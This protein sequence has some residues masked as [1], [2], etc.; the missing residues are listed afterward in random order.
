MTLAPSDL[1][2]SGRLA[3]GR[4]CILAAAI[5]WSLS[6][7]LTKTLGGLDGPTIAF[8]RGLF[9]GLALWPLVPPRRWS[10]RPGMIPLV[11]MFG[12]MTG[13]FI[14]S[15]TLTTA[16][17][18]IFLQYS[19]ALWT[20]PLSLLLLRERPDRR[21]LVGTAV[22]AAGILLI[23]FL[24]RGQGGPN[25]RLGIL[26]AL[27]SGVCYASVAVGMRILRAVDP[28]WLSVVN[29]LGG[30]LVLGA[31]LLAFRGSIPIPQPWQLALLIA[32]G[33]VQMAIPYALFAKGLREIS[34]PE[35][36]LISLV[37]P[38]LNPLWV[39]LFVG[40]V[41]E[42]STILGGCLLL[43]GVALRYAP[44][45]GNLRRNREPSS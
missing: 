38:V 35:A 20:I 13:L 39:L 19:S 43:T 9:A 10:F 4:R 12:G 33:L 37:E 29:N 27:A 2:A 7:V 11:I 15:I 18:A 31:G 8:Y 26:L 3:A 34:A 24:N 40:E 25:D 1:D 6:G 17:N 22:A 45:H 30:S 16:A 21:T 36:G 5:L 28:M 32:F 44:L 42:Y 41:P 23:V 14:T